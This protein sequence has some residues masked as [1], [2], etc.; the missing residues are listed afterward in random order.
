[1]S[2]G[3]GLPDVLKGSNFIKTCQAQVSGRYQDKI[4][5]GRDRPQ[6]AVERRFVFAHAAVA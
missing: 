3:G 1:M 2:A 5:E 6:P 4:G